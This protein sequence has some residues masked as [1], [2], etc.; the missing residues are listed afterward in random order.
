[1]KNNNLRRV[2][3]KR[4]LAD[5]PAVIA[6][7]AGYADLLAGKGFDSWRFADQIE[8]NNYEIGRLWALNIKIAG[9]DPPKWQRGK[10]VPKVVLARLNHSFEV[11]GGC[12][13]GEGDGI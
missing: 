3:P 9:L 4:G 8:Q 5:H 10:N 12:Q 13:P 6:A 11:A 1:M 2:I 7:Q